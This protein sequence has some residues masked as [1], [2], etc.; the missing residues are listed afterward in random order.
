MALAVESWTNKGLWVISRVDEEYP[1]RLKDRLK[2]SAPPVLYG[3]GRK[4]LLSRKGLAIVGSRNVDA[5]AVR[6]TRLVAG[7][8][9]GQDISVISGAARGVDGEAMDAAL[10]KGGSV[11]GLLAGGLA[12]ESSSMR[13]R[14]AIM[15]GSLVLVSPY[16]PY[17][18]FSVGN[19]MGRNRHIYAMSEWALVVSA[20]RGEGG[21]W[22]GASENLKRRWAPLFVRS[23]KRVPDGNVH[24]LESGG[25]PLPEEV[26]NE[27]A[28]LGK[29]LE[30]QSL[31][32]SPI[33]TRKTVPLAVA[34]RQIRRETCPAPG[35]EAERNE[36]AMDSSPAPETTDPFDAVW[37]HIEAEL[38]HAKTSRELAELLHV[39]QKQMTSWLKH[40][41]AVGKVTKLLR[42]VRYVMADHKEA[43]A[44]R[45]LTIPFKRRGAG[46]DAAAE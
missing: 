43:C 45:Q 21:T 13:F 34:G 18:H 2:R 26:L 32:S 37:P 35:T 24:L 40:A 17:A 3:S 8:C 20:A 22:T 29:W 25:I 23:G 41:A 33:E 42:P 1:Q 6:Y 15:D 5:E 38:K 36:P 4:E 16:Y 10:K 7:L 11:A 30:D 12:R 31:L 46:E 27:R 44:G 28:D 9:A 14:E 39:S 19:A